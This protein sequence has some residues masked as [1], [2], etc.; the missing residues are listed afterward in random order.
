MDKSENGDCCWR[1]RP[2]PEDMTD[3]FP[4]GKVGGQITPG[5]AALDRLADGL[6]EAPAGGGRAVD[7]P[8]LVLK[9]YTVHF[10]NDKTLNGFH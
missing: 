1:E 2:L 5:D 8:H 10:Q 6:K 3:G 9:Y 4:R 7:S